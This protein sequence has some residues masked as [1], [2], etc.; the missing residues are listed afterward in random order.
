MKRVRQTQTTLLLLSLSLSPWH[1]ALG[2]DVDPISGNTCLNCHAAKNSGFSAAH[3]FAASNCVSCHAGNNHADT[4][5]GAHEDL[6]AFP[7]L[8]L[9]A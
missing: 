3:E 6:I 1:L 7:G 4:E 9:K 5:D 8:P 2:D